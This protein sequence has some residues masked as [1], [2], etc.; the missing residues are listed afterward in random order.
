MSKGKLAKFAE[1]KEMPN[2]FQNFNWQQPQLINHLG[3]EVNYKNQWHEQV[4]GNNNPIVLELGCGYGEYTVAMAQQ[5]PNHNI[6][7]I[8]IKGNRIHMGAQWLL[9]NRVN[10]AIFV[11]TSIE[12]L[13]HYFGEQEISEIWLPFP[14]PFR[15]DSKSNRRLTSGYFINIYRQIMEPDGVVHLKTDSTLLYEYTLESIAENGCTLLEEH[16][17]LYGSN[18]TN[19]LL[20][21]KTRYEK[22]NLSKAETIKYIKFRL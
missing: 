15:R 6:I 7:G 4:F 8:D 12:L 2:V 22:L 9:D 16:Y 17:N 11:R 21:V 5:M 10:N 3:N 19:A 13:T 18:P 1:L 14:D 20:H